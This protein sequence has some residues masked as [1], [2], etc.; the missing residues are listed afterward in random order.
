MD[1]IRYIPVK[2]LSVSIRRISSLRLA[3]HVSI[4]LSIACQSTYV[5]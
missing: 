3:V 1:G 4:N 5:S 2:T